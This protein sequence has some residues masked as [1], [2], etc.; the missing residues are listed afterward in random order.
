MIVYNDRYHGLLIADK[1]GCIFHTEDTCISRVTSGGKL[2]G[3]VIFTDYNTNSIQLHCASFM[4]NW[5]S[6]DLLS[7]VF[8]YVFDELECTKAFAPVPSNN[9]AALALDYKLGFKYVTT[10]PGIFVDADLVVLDME[11]DTCRW[12]GSE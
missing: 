8:G 5:L 2:M 9:D 12:L 6:K 1:A 11:R 7:A 4:P 10:V 3:G